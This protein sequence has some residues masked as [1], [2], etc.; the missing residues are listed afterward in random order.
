MNYNLVFRGENVKKGTDSERHRCVHKG[1]EYK[2]KSR[3]EEKERDILI[4]LMEV[5]VKEVILEK[6]TE[7]EKSLKRVS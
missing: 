1:S 4:S 7:R 6:S 5:K 2:V 3:Y